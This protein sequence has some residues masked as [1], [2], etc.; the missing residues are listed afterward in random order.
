[1]AEFNIGDVVRLKSGGP[2][3]TVTMVPESPV[4]SYKCEWFEG[5]T[6]KEGLFPGAALQTNPSPPRS[7]AKPSHGWREH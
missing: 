5:T 3:M 4:E 2:P 1:M 6:P 7:I